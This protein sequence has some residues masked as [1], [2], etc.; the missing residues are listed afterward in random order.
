MSSL[1]SN[2]WSFRLQAVEVAIAAVLFLLS[3]SA[4]AGGT[5]VLDDTVLVNGGRNNAIVSLNA[6]IKVSF[7]ANDYGYGSS[8]YKYLL[9]AVYKANST[10]RHVTEADIK[11][12]RIFC[13][14]MNA[15]SRDGSRNGGSHGVNTDYRG[16]PSY[17][18]D[19]SVPD[20]PGD[21]RIVYGAI[22]QFTYT[23]LKDEVALYSSFEVDGVNRGRL[24]ASKN[25]W[26]KLA[27]FKVSSVDIPTDALNVYLRVNDKLPTAVKIDNGISRNPLNISWFVGENFPLDKSKVKFRYQMWPDDKG[28]SEW[29]DEKGVSYFFL[30]K[31]T[32]EIW[33]ESTYDEGETHIQSGTAK[34]GFVLKDNFVAK[35]MTK[36]GEAKPFTGGMAREQLNKP[37]KDVYRKSLALIVGVW[38]F[39]DKTHFQTFGQKRISK[40]VATLKSALELNG[41]DV[42]TLIK[43]RVTRDEIM[44]ALEKI[45]E[46]AAKDDRIFIYFSSHGFPDKKFPTDAYIATSDCSMDAPSVKCLRIADV[47]HQA[48]RLLEAP[49]AEVKQVLIAVDSCFSGLGVITKSANSPNLS[50]LASHQGAFMLTAGM[51]DQLAEIDPELDM[52]TFTYF[53]SEGLSGKADILKSS[54]GVITLTE[55]LL[56]VQ[57]SVAEQTNSRQIPMLGRFKGDGEMLFQPKGR[58]Q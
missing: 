4:L 48:N 33:V 35:P 20:I 52:S 24:L 14:L 9:I 36:G 46:R 38:S 45:V 1:Q 55:L 3:T 2:L 53:L 44:D 51:A 40:D 19:F 58:G 8:E 34:F 28:W 27:E 11:K 57:S 7:R 41:F 37:F 32:H 18:L 22:P 49:G 6:P 42:T 25:Y 43:E 47:E 23:P 31:G 16:M 15:P 26:E 54:D 5:V 39:D 13:V 50:Q 56:Y 17:N 29:A 21:Y 10:D 30:P 12:S